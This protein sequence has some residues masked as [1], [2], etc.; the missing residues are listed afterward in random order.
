MNP[1]RYV[2]AGSG[3]LVLIVFSVLTLPARA[4]I[5]YSN[6]LSLYGWMDQYSI[7]NTVQ[8]E[9]NA[10]GPEACVPTSSVN[11][12]VYLQNLN[13][14]LFGT[15]FTGGTNYSDWYTTDLTLI[16]LYGTTYASGTYYNQFVYALQ[17]FIQNT[18]GFSQVSF[19]SMFPS[20]IWS[21]QYPDPSFNVNGLPSVDFIS[22]ALGSQSALLISI[23]YSKGGGH[24]LL[25]NAIS[26]DTN[27]LTGT[28]S[29][30]DP[31][32]PSLSY[33]GTNV[34]GTALETTG[35]LSL[36]TNGSLIMNY[37]QYHAGLPYSN[38]FGTVNVSLS[39]AL[40]LTVVPEPAP[41]SLVLGAGAL[42]LLLRWILR[43]A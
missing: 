18:H 43:K 29:F 3:L 24:E 42:L 8:S 27:S 33:S 34:L 21:L 40:A 17:N 7:T 6:N 16:N 4:Q 39:G 23:E 10:V 32:D 35:N 31:L 1:F 2:G 25:A 12:L 38:S 15:A 5:S 9:T 36:D 41:M 11:A 26:W 30:I 37:S 19:A 20:N 13:P 14:P 22:N 28:L